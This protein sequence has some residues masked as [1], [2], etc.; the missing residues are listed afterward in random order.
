M[1]TDNHPPKRS[2]LR[3]HERILQERRARNFE[4]E[5]KLAE[6]TAVR[7]KE[8]FEGLSKFIHANGAWLVSAPS[9]ILPRLWRMDDTARF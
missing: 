2:D 5:L 9:A 4:E 6:R 8:L 7:R 3:A 1:A